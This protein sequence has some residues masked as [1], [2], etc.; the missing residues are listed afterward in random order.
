MCPSHESGGTHASPVCKSRSTRTSSRQ[1]HDGCR[2]ATFSRSAQQPKSRGAPALREIIS[3]EAAHVVVWDQ[4]G[5]A[6]RP[7]GPEWAALM[8]TAGFEPRATLVRCGHRRGTYDRVRIRH[9]CAVCHFSRFAKR[10][11]PRW[12]CPECRAIGLEGKLRMERCLQPITDH[13]L[14]SECPFCN[15]DP[16]RLFLQAELIV[17]VWDAFP[18]GRRT[19]AV[20]YTSPRG[21]LVRCDRPRTTG[22]DRR[23]RLRPPGD[24]AAS[25]TRRLQHRR[26]RW[27]GGGP[28]GILTCTFTSFPDTAATFPTRA[29]GYGT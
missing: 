2:R 8:R 18:G 22:A 17:G 24:S 26:E 16:D 23:D 7:H 9:F 3:H 28:N 11:M 5:H 14:Q 12:R 27:R 6:A 21:E 19:R 25:C 15:P 10:R 4:S 29:A 13:M 1:S 20:G